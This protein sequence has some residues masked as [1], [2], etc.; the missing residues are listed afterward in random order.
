MPAVILRSETWRHKAI[1]LDERLEH[2]DRVV[3]APR[4][5]EAIH[6]RECDDLSTFCVGV[7]VTLPN[8]DSGLECLC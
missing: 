8:A 5:R 2:K 3:V 4:R 7:E 6:W 1:S